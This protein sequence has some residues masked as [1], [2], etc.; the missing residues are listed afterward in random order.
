MENP[1]VSL[2]ARGIQPR[3]RHALGKVRGLH[4][5]IDE[6]FQPLRRGIGEEGRRF[7][8]ARRQPGE[9]EENAA[10][11]D[12]RR[13][14]RAGRKALIGEAGADKGIHRI[15]A[16]RAG[17]RG[18]DRRGEGPVAFIDRAVGDPFFERRDLLGLERRE[19]GFG[20]R[21][22][23]LRLGGE[24]ALDHGAGL[25]L[26]GDDGGTA[27]ARGD[28]GLAKIQPEL[29]AAMLRIRAMAQKTISRED[30]ADPFSIRS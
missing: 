26:A 29:T 7:R 13:G 11:E 23:I 9:V 28:G 30:G 21:H 14:F 5:P 4:Q 16:G 1:W 25:R 18:F 19:V 17:Q 24:D 2:I 27:F 12:F 10:D 20:R 3:H 22:D 8:K 15:A 6:L